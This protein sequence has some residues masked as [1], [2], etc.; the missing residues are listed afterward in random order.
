MIVHVF[1]IINGYLCIPLIYDISKAAK[2]FKANTGKVPTVFIDGSDVLCIFE[3]SLFNHLHYQAKELANAEVMTIVFVSS[4][5]PYS[6]TV[7]HF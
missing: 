7:I 1:I 4:D 6:T 2:T 5:S 3:S